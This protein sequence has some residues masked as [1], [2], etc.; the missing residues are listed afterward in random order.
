[1]KKIQIWMNREQ[2][3]KGKREIIDQSK[4]EKKIVYKKKIKKLLTFLFHVS[5]MLTK[6]V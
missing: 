5:Y 6:T 3:G 1:M 4:F 2:N